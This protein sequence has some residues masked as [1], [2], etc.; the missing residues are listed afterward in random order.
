MGL[1]SALNTSLNGLSLN[2]TAIDVLGN[3][4]ANAGTNGFK[5]SNVLFTT[6]LSRTLSV[7]SAPSGDN[8]GTNPRQ[9]G[10]GAM[11]AAIS[12][13]LTQGG[14]TN[15]TSPSDL[16]IQGDGF[17]VLEAPAGRTYSRAGN[18]AL[19]SGN[20]LVDSTGQRVQ[21][22]G[23]N[24]EFVLQTETPTDIEIRLGLDKVAQATR[25]V[26]LAGSL[27]T[28]AEA[29]AGTLGTI[30]TAN[31]LTDTSGGDP[32]VDPIDATT[33]LTSV[34]SS[35]G[36][37][38]LFALNDVIEFSA[39]KGARQ[40]QG[41]SLTVTAGATVADLL[42]LFDQALGIQDNTD[43]DNTIPDDGVAGVQPGVRI[44]GGAGAIRVVGNAGTANDLYIAAG[45]IKINGVDLDLGFNKSQAA[46]GESAMLDFGVF[47][48]LGQKVDVAIRMN[49]ESRNASTTTYRFLI[50]SV[51]DSDADIVITNGTLV[52]DN[53][54]NVAND[55]TGNGTAGVT[56]QRADTAADTLQFTLDLT[57]LSGIVSSSDDSKLLP[58]AQ[59]GSAPGTLM[60]F[61]IDESGIINGVFDNGIIRTLGQVV[62]ARFSNTQG[63]IESGQAAYQEGVSSGPA[64]IVT[65]GSSGA[66]TIRSGA[67]E[68]SNTDIGRNLVNLIVA[69]TNYR[70]NARVISSIQQLVDELLVLGR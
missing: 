41:Q 9:I 65:P 26:S 59:D 38:S 66:G 44:D 23:V 39:T 67:I 4:I 14:V 15:S 31:P 52:F 2:E 34:Y 60:S 7:G 28:S 55:T 61:V 8:A 3:N 64:Q 24:D 63:L 21:G 18:F 49:L 45:D 43:G 54:G 68:L 37:T 56:I 13:D 6:Q 11:T 70:G 25:N 62:L 10:L 57:D 51:D 58:A 30:L 27:R 36:A 53:E 35:G 48:S 22:Y 19:N 1:T 50:E 12:K 20:L 16:A 46:N 42:T 17:F 29:E 32:A 5:S 69:S 40:I 33:L 47:D